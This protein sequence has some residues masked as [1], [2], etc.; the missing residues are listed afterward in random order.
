MLLTSEGLQESDAE[1]EEG[2]YLWLPLLRCG[3]VWRAQGQDPPA[4]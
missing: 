3:Q 2:G 4:V 1:E